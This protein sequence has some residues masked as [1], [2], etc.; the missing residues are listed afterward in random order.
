ADYIARGWCFVV[1]QLQPATSEVVVPRP[2]MATFTTSSPVF[3]M[4]ATSLA[5]TKTRVEL[6]VI[7]DQE[8]TAQNFT[9]PAAAD[10]VRSNGDLATSPF[11]HSKPAKLWIGSPDVVALMWN[12]CVVTKLQADW[13]P[14]QMDTDVT[15]HFKPLQGGGHRDHLFSTMARRHIAAT[16]LLSAAVAGLLIAAVIYRHGRKASRG[17]RRFLLRAVGVIVGAGL[18]VWLLLPTIPVQTGSWASEWRQNYKLRGAIQAYYVKV[19]EEDDL[20]DWSAVNLPQV[21]LNGGFIE[22]PIT[23]PFT[24]QPVR[25]ERSPGNFDVRKLDGMWQL[26]TYNQDGIEQR[27]MELER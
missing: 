23:N 17:Q 2:L 13:P 19:S 10:F 11:Y 12:N 8:A 21:L 6:C 24:G 26:C 18:G 25:R 20:P 15:I 16:I 5:K 3:P 22:S 1:T 9:S 14:T 4:K 7:S 27:T